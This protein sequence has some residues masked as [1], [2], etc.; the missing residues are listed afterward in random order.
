MAVIA[1]RVDTVTATWAIAR[2]A[3]GL[4]ARSGHPSRMMRDFDLAVLT[5]ADLR[6]DR[7]IGENVGALFDYPVEEV[8]WAKLEA[9]FQAM[10]S[11][12]QAHE[13]LRRI[14]AACDEYTRVTIE[15]MRETIN[16]SRKRK[17]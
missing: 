5:V 4:M 11:D 10:R 17:N 6:T 2:L 7:L 14:K 9:Q 16:R 1:D 12:D 15:V 8:D 13:G 3:A